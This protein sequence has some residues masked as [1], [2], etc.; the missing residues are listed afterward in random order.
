[1][2]AG[3]VSLML[4]GGFCG[5]GYS[6]IFSLFFGISCSRGLTNPGPLNCV[7]CHLIFWGSSGP[8]LLLVMV[9]VPI[10]LGNW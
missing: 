6:S 2:T 10:V 8:I 3:M 4:G 5:F 9:L 7:R 1:V